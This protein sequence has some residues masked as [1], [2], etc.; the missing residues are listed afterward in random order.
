MHFTISPIPGDRANTALRDATVL[1]RA[2]VAVARGQRD[3]IEALAAH[4]RD[5]IERGF[6]AVQISLN[7]M[8]RFHAKGWL[9]RATAKS[10]YRAIDHIPPLKS[11]LLAR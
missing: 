2:L 5:M 3:L 8:R 7:D 4:E 9:A 1:R 10:L 6:A 11:A